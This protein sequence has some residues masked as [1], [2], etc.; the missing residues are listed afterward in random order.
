MTA[1]LIH[2]MRTLQKIIVK[3]F[4]VDH[5]LFGTK[6]K[7]EYEYAGMKYSKKKFG[8]S[9]TLGD[10]GLFRCFDTVTDVLDFSVQSR[11]AKS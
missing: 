10:S 5:G 7:F 6:L 8:E 1:G 11:T 9:P 3:N 4:S 2:D